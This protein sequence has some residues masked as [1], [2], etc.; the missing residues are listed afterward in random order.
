MRKQVRAEYRIRTPR[1]LRHRISNL[2]DADKTFCELIALLHYDHS[3]AYRIAYN[4][5]AKDS[6]NASMACRRVKDFAVEDYIQLLQRY[7]GENALP[8]YNWNRK[9]PY[10]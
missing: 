9:N 3:T 1:E 6:S 7:Y 4:N 2:S 8:P 10:Y 5:R